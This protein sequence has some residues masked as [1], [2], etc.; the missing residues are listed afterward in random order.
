MPGDPSILK[1]L[2]PTRSYIS[3]QTSQIRGFAPIFHD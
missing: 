2:P 3:L 1:V